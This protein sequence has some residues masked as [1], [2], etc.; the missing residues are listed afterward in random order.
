[1]STGEQSF[2]LCDLTAHFIFAWSANSEIPLLTMNNRARSL[3]QASRQVLEG[4][5]PRLCIK[6]QALR[7]IHTQ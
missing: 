7:I 3:M 5:D 4:E 2:A 6:G 1:M